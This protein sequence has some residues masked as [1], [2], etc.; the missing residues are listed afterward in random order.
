[1]KW[2]ED[3]LCD[4]SQQVVMDGYSSD[5]LPVN[6]GVPQGTIL[7]L[8]L[9]FCYINDLPECVSCNICLYADGVPLYN[10]IES[11]KDCC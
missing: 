11:E 6:S 7:D 9:F 10:I 5:D 1:L 8:L 2:I 3:F 4:H